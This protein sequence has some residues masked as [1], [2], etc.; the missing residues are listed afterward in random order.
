MANGRRPPRV[1]L[2]LLFGFIILAG[3]GQAVPLYT[4]WLW[5]VEVGFTQVFT[6]VLSLRGWLFLGAGG[7]VFIFVYGNLWLAARTAAPDVLWELD[8]QLGLPGRAVLEPLIRKLLLPVIAVIGILSGLWASASWDMVLGY[9]NRSAFGATDPLFGRDI[10]FFVFELPL[11]RFL[12]SGAMTLVL[13]TLLLSVATYVLLRSLVLTAQG[14]RLAAGARTHLLALGALLLVLRAL[15][16]WLDRYELVYSPRGVVFGAS[17]TDVH[18]ALPVLGALTA[19]A[20]LCAA[21]CLFQMT[22]PGWGFLVAGLVVLG[23]AWA[24]GLGIWPALLQ[25]FQVMPNELVAERPYIEHNIRMTRQAYGLNAVKEQDFAAEE[26]LTSAALERNALTIKNIRLW[27]HR[28]LLTS[29]GQ[30]QEIRTYYKFADVDVDRYLINNELRQIMLSARELSYP[31]LPSRVWINEHLTFTHGYGLVAGPVNRVTPEG[32]PDL[33]VKDI[34][35]ISTGGFPKITRPQIYYGELSNEYVIVR[36]RS[37]ELDYPS[38]DQNVYS[39]YTGRGGVPMNGLRKLAFAMRFGEIKI[40]LSDDLTA[41]SR[42]MMYRRVAERVRQA[43]PFLRYDHD[44]YFVVTDDGRL[45]WIIDAYT[46][47]DRYPYAQPERGLNYIRNSVKVTVDAFDGTMVFYVVDPADPLIRAWARAFPRLFTP[48][49]RMPANLRAHVRY[50][51]DLFT[52]Q[53]KMY[54]TYHMQDPQVFYNK[55]D[56]WTIPRLT[57]EGRDREMEPYFTIMRLPGGKAEE[58]VL[59]SGFNP[60]RRDNMIAILAARSDAP[61]YGGLIVYTFPKQK[62]VYGPRQI[63]ARVN[64]DPVISAQFSLWN[65]QGSRVLRGSLLAIPIEDSLIYVQPIYLSA[66]QGALPELRRVIVA[67]GNQIA[68]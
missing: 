21:A 20:L 44:P 39:R 13:G 38:G 26:R 54:G 28:P 50:P 18:A 48:F 60:A 23:V 17:Y 29:F 47:T 5:Y 46:T 45:V 55:E 36:T 1:G 49:E 58:F 41:E 3:A 16:F 68:M 19:L 67:F 31:H 9:I 35:P 15:G 8:D 52:L 37:Q 10:A 53:A 6:T 59:L 25:R 56:L 32:L 27:D 62:L 42:L 61:N 40:L 64:Q 66:E 33:F 30:L 34:P 63:D 12:Y 57:Q 22:R 24:G 51:E 4:D 14:P 7:A 65:Q 11:W 2:W 43:A